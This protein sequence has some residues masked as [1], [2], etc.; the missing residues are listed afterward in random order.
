MNGPQF[1]RTVLF[2]AW[3]SLGLPASAQAGPATQVA[4]ELRVGALG[5]S[6]AIE[7]SGNATFDTDSI[8]RA[9]RYN[10]GFQELSDPAGSLRPLTALVENL[11]RQ[12]Y[13]HGGFPAVTV[14]AEPD[15]TRIRLQIVEGGQY[16][17]GAVRISG[18]NSTELEGLH[19]RVAAALHGGTNFGTTPSQ[20]DLWPAGQP[21][22][23]DDATALL[24]RDRVGAV[25][26]EFHQIRPKLDVMVWP[27]SGRDTATLGIV[28][29]DAGVQGVVTGFEIHGVDAA[30]HG[31]LLRF[32]DLAPGQPIT[33]SLLSGIT[34]R[35]WSSA[36]FVRH[37]VA[38]LPQR[39][40]GSQVLRLDLASLPWVPPIS[41][42][43]SPTEQ[44]LIR[45]RNWLSTPGTWDKDL[46]LVSTRHAGSGT[47]RVTVTTG[48]SG[49][50]IAVSTTTNRSEPRLQFGLIGNTGAP[51]LY[52]PGRHRKFVAPSAEGGLLAYAELIPSQDPVRDPLLLSLGMGFTSSSSS[53]SFLTLRLGGTPAAFAQA[54]YTSNHS[55]VLEGNRTLVIRPKTDLTNLVIRVDA[56]SG[57]LRSLDWKGSDGT[58]EM[59]FRGFLKARAGETAARAIRDAGRNDTNDYVAGRGVVSFLSHVAGDLLDSEVLE[60]DAAREFLAAVLDPDHA[61]PS[62]KSVDE[63]KDALRWLR[64][65]ASGPPGKG[66][67]DAILAP[68]S[69]VLSQEDVE[70]A[71]PNFEIVEASPWTPG[72]TE[73]SIVSVARWGLALTD[74]L[75]PRGSWTWTL[76][77]ESLLTRIAPERGIDPQA[78]RLF[79]SPE[80]GPFGCL[81]LANALAETH[82]LWARR[83]ALLGQRRTSLEALRQDW[84]LLTDTN[85]AMGRSVGAALALLRSAPDLP[86]F[87]TYPRFTPEQSAFLIQAVLGLRASGESSPGE[88]VWPV[89]ARHWEP[90]LRPA[91]VASLAS[92]ASPSTHLAQPDALF[93]RGVQLHGTDADDSDRVEGT[94]CLR[95]AAEAGHGEAQRQYGLVLYSGAGTPVDQ[96]AGIQWLERAAAAGVPHARCDL[97]RI[98]FEGRNGTPDLP[99]AIR[100]FRPEAEEQNCPA[101]QYY[102]AAIAE[103]ENRTEESLQWLRR[104]ATQGNTQARILLADRLSDGFTT[105]PEYSEAFYWL[106]LSG[107]EASPEVQPLLKLVRSHLT[108]DQMEEITRRAAAASSTTR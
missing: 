64:G 78:L 65:V 55:A 3:I 13:L 10:L 81:V 76:A 63:T 58:N 108:V 61:V 72:S 102:M 74:K 60:S 54:A 25:L 89:I 17:C 2:L 88:A 67:L 86:A 70:G 94:A 73:Q 68:L 77:R 53:N 84:N 93:A 8:R 26:A 49:M 46:V 92:L 6:E 103:R 99:T 62:D 4:D 96:S 35:L 95:K 100:W 20:P 83:F 19:A 106:T 7:P 69:E 12:G 21:A 85:T 56:A 38:L 105:R 32:L 1:R 91:L 36:R 80:T 87:R 29:L 37:D 41:V 101:A 24:I 79:Q 43:S 18:V 107:K 40:P 71:G 98:A 44:A 59:E 5:R 75:C 23:F 27:D 45:F 57:A 104:S 28:L 33:P 66:G 82:P 11:V 42:P 97:G 50:T 9:L 30:Q 16:R 34:N 48:P 39:D 90:L 14:H 15:R 31:D 22:P 47:G 52:A 51:E